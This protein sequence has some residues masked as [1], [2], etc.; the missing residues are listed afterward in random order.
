MIAG[1]QRMAGICCLV[2]VACQPAE[3]VA[4]GALGPPLTSP[5]S[6]GGASLADQALVTFLGMCDASGAVPLS[7]KVFLVADDEDNVLRAYDGT[8]GGG[9]LW[10]VELSASIGI[11]SKK[12]GPPEADIEAATVAD[13][14]AFWIT[15]HGRNSSGKLK[16][17][18]FRLFATTLASDAASLTVVGQPYE[19]LLGDVLND[20]RFAP[21][22]LSAAAR[23]PPKAEG[24]LNIE[25]MTRRREGGV[26][27]GLRSPKPR[28]RALVFPL[29]NP[30][31][32]VL[33]G[34]ARAELG[35][36]VLLDLGGMG[37]RALSRV[38]NDYL[39][40]AGHH[41]G[42]AGS[43]LYR[44]DGSGAPRLIRT[45]TPEGFNTEG[46]FSP[47]GGS[48]VL[49]LSDD[50]ARTLDGIECKKV[51]NFDRKSFR[52]MWLKP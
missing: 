42:T 30:R 45:D 29:L 32:L 17:E 47:Q 14:L 37:V 36:P 27:I 13:G 20:P 24:G 15:S 23:L 38:G 52:G 19:G 2:T 6:N 22:A 3:S 50:G 33:E 41:D 48:R 44:W 34:G 28:G 46:F 21:F 35:D 26:W 1:M 7:E 40:A 4:P 9:P 10:S 16:T 25:G 12:K 5:T 39:L 8:R 11:P 31:S 18:R 51:P 49:A 43:R